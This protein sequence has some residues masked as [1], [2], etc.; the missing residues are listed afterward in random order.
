M[1]L[2]PV[3][4]ADIIAEP[5]MLVAICWVAFYR[6]L[7]T[8]E[9]CH[10]SSQA[11]KQQWRGARRVGLALPKGFAGPL[12]Y[13]SESAGSNSGCPWSCTSH[14]PDAAVPYT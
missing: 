5:A 11:L 9:G 13:V 2:L 12:E 14:C 4:V 6:V 1:L 8:L 7:Y 3:L 10:G